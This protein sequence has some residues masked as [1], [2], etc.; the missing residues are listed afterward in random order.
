M[1]GIHI[2]FPT[3]N[4]LVNVCKARVFCTLSVTSHGNLGP[5][6]HLPYSPKHTL[7]F[8]VTAVTLS[9]DNIDKYNFRNITPV[10][11]EMNIPHH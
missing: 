10:L 3:V 8:E 11:K 2:N 6:S 4:G 9:G 5:I 7:P 1:R